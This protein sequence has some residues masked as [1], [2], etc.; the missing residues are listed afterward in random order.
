MYE[1]KKSVAFTKLIEIEY[2]SNIPDI[3]LIYAV[4]GY[5]IAMI[6]MSS[7]NR[8]NSLLCFTLTLTELRFRLCVYVVKDTQSASDIIL[9]S[10][11]G[12]ANHCSFLQVH[13]PRS[14]CFSPHGRESNTPQQTSAINKRNITASICCKLSCKRVQIWFLPFR[15]P[16][17]PHSNKR[18]SF[19]WV[20]LQAFLP[21]RD[22]FVRPFSGPFLFAP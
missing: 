20:R 5:P 3:Q 18:F 21:N 19:V 16:Y 4:I 1:R 17:F 11:L 2:R 15:N 12:I 6:W 22:D 14:L 8:I 13:I 10:E 7:N 9:V